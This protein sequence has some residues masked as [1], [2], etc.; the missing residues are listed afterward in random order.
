MTVEIAKIVKQHGS[1]PIENT[2]NTI[3]STWIP[4]I[5]YG[6]VWYL[7]YCQLK[8][9]VCGCE[10][11]IVVFTSSLPRTVACEHDVAREDK[12]RWRWRRRM[13]FLRRFRRS[14]RERLQSHWR[15]QVWPGRPERR[16][17]LRLLPGSVQRPDVRAYPQERELALQGPSY[18]MA[19]LWPEIQQLKNIKK[20]LWKWNTIFS[21]LRYAKALT[22]HLLVWEVR[23]CKFDNI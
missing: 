22:T 15:R 2:N 12:R 14:K 20:N 3:I 19:S 4:D 17:R 13:R 10:I 18:W 1:C 5:V 11:F 7:R 8:T 23:V 16:C 9:K 6:H 21:N